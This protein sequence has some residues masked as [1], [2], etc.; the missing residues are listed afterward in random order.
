MFSG[1]IDK[2]GRI[3]AVTPNA[4][5]QTL[6]VSAADDYWQCVPLGAS[7]AIDGVCLT[8]TKIDGA[9]AHFDV[10]AETLRRSTLG[11]LQ[12]G[13]AVNLQKSM[14]VGDRIDGHFVQG[15]VDAV[16]VVDEIV[17]GD[18]SAMWWFKAENDAMRMIV[19]KGSITIDGI[20][21]TVAAREAERFAVALIPTTLRET[22][23]GDKRVGQT[24]NLE[25]DILVRTIAHLLHDG[26]ADGTVGGITLSYLQANGFA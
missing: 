18:L 20:S 6:Q 4:G 7:I 2:I 21:L 19:P 13:D 14:R 24:V 15:H 17:P 11:G 22:K 5:G 23:I 16:G 12:A 1:I 8:V 10:V 9:V 26:K 25:T 3:T